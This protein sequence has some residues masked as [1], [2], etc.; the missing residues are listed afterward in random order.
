MSLYEMRKSYTLATLLEKDI[1]PNPMVQ[2]KTWLA[3]ALQGDLPDWVEVNAMTLSTS[4]GHG[5]VTSRIVLLKGIEQDKF[6]FYTNYA[7]EKAAQMEANPS[8]SLCFLW[9]HLQRQ[10][11]VTGTIAKAPRQQSIDY[12]H[13][14]PRD[15]QFGAIV[16]SQSSV[17]ESRE[18]LEKRLAE[19]KQQYGENDTIECPEDWG[20][21]CVSPT[22]IEFWQGRESRLHD[23]LRYRSN[24]SDWVVER[25]AP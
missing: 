1:D 20:G 13:K 9:Q 2:F 4:D 25:L 14:R 8:V 11:R 23:R 7:S 18:V 10:V 22:A 12:F 5:N 3:D 6:W 19:L 24:G 15:S 16:S 21:Y 17:V